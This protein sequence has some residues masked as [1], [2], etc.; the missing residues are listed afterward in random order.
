MA[1]TR[2]RM[3]RLRA[4]VAFLFAIAYVLGTVVFLL[5]LAD[6]GFVGALRSFGMDLA[7]WFVLLMVAGCMAIFAYPYE[8][9]SRRMRVFGRAGR[10]GARSGARAGS[11]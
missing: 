11:P 4:S 7:G 5:L 2:A 9:P 6:R 3:S 8:R 10:L 1:E